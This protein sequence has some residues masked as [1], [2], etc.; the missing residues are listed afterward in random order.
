MK[1]YALRHAYAPTRGADAYYENYRVINVWMYNLKDDEFKEAYN[2]VVSTNI[3]HKLN[4]QDLSR[5]KSWFVETELFNGLLITN[6]DNIHLGDIDFDSSYY[7]MYDIVYHKFIQEKDAE[8]SLRHAIYILDCSQHK[9]YCI[10][11]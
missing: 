9:Y 11:R 3:W 1:G 5:F 10:E 6:K 8:Y 2:F 4:E 7:C